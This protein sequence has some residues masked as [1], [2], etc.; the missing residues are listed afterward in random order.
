MMIVDPA[1]AVEAVVDRIGILSKK[2][3]L[4]NTTEVEQ[5]DEKVSV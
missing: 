4:K 3:D 1:V 2:V 5:V